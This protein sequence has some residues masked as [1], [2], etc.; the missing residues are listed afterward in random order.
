MANESKHVI[1]SCLYEKIAVLTS[2]M[3]QLEILIQ[4]IK[5]FL[6]INF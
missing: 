2:A 5:T 6:K 3:A 1:T 4:G